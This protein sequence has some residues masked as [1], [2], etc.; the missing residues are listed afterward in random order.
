MPSLSEP[1][2]ETFPGPA[3]QTVLALGGAAG[4]I[5]LDGDAGEDFRRFPGD[6][7]GAE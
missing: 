3:H 6:P 4:S 2:H 7:L 1:R 5:R